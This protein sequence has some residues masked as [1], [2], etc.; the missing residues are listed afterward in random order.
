MLPMTEIAQKVPREISI[1]NGNCWVAFV[2]LR[3]TRS[4]LAMCTIDEDHGLGIITKGHQNTIDVYEEDINW[5]NFC[6]NR[7]EWMNT[8]T[9][10]EFYSICDC[11]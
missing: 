4:D 10:Q 5:E 7:T 9:H 2:Q 11:I 6:K 8:M 3:A 1:W